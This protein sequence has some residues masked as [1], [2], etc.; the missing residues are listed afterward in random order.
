MWNNQL[1]LPLDEV[2]TG[3]LTNIWGTTEGIIS[4]RHQ[5]HMWIG[6]D[7]SFHLVA[8]QG[9]NKGLSL[10]SSFDEGASWQ[11]MLSVADTNNTST[12]DGFLV[13]NRLFLISSS[14]R[15]GINV[16]QLD[17]DSFHQQWI[18]E[19]STTI[20]QD[21]NFK[22]SHPT[23][24]M[25]TENRLW[26]TFTTRDRFT[27]QSKINILYSEDDG[28]NWQDS[29]VTLAANNFEHRKSARVINLS[30][31]VV[32]IYSD[33]LTLNWAYRLNRWS[34]DEPWQKG[35]LFEYENPIQKDPRGTHFSVVVDRFD[36]IHIATNDGQRRLLYLKYDRQQN[37]WL[38]PRIL[39]DFNSA[40]YM[41]ISLSED[42]RLLIAYDAR[43]G[44]I[45]YLEVIESFDYGETFSDGTSMVFF[46]GKN[47]GNPRL[48]T[49]AF[50][51]GTLPVL[52]QIS[53]QN[54][55]IQGLVYFDYELLESSFS[56][57]ESLTDSVQLNLDGLES[58]PQVNVYSDS[59]DIL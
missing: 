27:K 16:S 7:G 59:P 8:K 34:L 57:P 2:I 12:S 58:E 40:S 19:Q 39:T 43:P 56:E 24:A 23:L 1:T 46:P 22:A 13:G 20:H 28:I 18:L 26:A 33:G 36:N 51:E 54:D 25:D 42:N 52:Q 55:Q 29:G 47:W 4:S 6:E 53:I 37:N 11:Y 9:D 49:P 48:E 30:N 15:R 41:Q 17:Y 45:S 50:V 5:E 21:V 31:A 35:L 44:N 3:H 10:F 32:A 14:S 38:E